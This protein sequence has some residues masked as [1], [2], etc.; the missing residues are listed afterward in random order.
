MPTKARSK[1]KTKKTKP[2][3]KKT[4][5]KTTRSAAK[6]SRKKAAKSK[7]SAR[8]TITAKRTRNVSGKKK[9]RKKPELVALDALEPKRARGR[10]GRQA[11]DL[12]GLSRNES[13]DSESVSDLLE[14]GNTF[15]AEAVAGVEAADVDEREVETHEV[16]E[17]D[18][19]EEYLD[20]D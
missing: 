14:E 19:P 1:N 18:V 10:S 7:T 12:L 16:P 6:I 5:A 13:A 11:G 3:A 20:E 9:A 17:D 8:Q 15:E 2:K 4:T